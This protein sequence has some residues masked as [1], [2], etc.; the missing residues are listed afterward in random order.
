M[1]NM[2]KRITIMM[3]SIAL[4]LP[5]VSNAQIYIMDEDEENN[6]V[7]ASSEEFWFN[8]GVPYQGGDADQSY[9][10]LADGL[11]LLAGLGACYLLKKRRKE[12]QE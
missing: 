1:K 6:S 12:G 3:M 8:G 9:T 2:K 11:L 5:V 4:L 7:R 10:P